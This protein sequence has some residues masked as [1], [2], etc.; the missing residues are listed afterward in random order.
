MFRLA[1]AEEII[2]RGTQRDALRRAA[3]MMAFRWTLGALGFIGF[4]LGSGYF[5]AVAPGWQFGV[6]IACLI[7]AVIYLFVR[8]ERQ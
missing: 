6:Y 7:S 5:I 2:A 4:G 1:T 8:Q 3:M